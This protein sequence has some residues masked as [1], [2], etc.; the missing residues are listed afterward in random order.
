MRFIKSFIA[1]ISRHAANIAILVILVAVVKTDLERQY[2]KQ[3]DRLL[4]WDVKVYYVY[5]PA[6]FIYH[7][8]S[9]KFVAEKKGELGEIM[10][11]EESPKGMYSI[12]TTYGQALLYAPFFFAAHAYSLLTGTWE[13]TGYSP[14]YKFG[15]MLSSVF[16]L[17]IGLFFLKKFLLKYF[18]P[19]VTGLTLIAIVLATNIYYYSTYEAAMTHAY[20]FSMI[21]VF[22]YFT[23]KW[24]EKTSVWNTIIIGF[25]IGLITLVRP[26]NLI[27]LLFFILWGVHSGQSLKERIFY[28]LKAYKWILLMLLIF[29][30]LWVPQFIYWKYISG[31]YLFYSYSDQRF[32]FDAPQ[33]FSSLFSY[34]KGLLVYIPILVFAFIGI[35]FLYKKYQGFILPVTVVIVVNIYVLSSWCFWWFG[36]GFGPRSYIDTYAFLAIPFAALTSWINRKHFIW[37]ILFLAITGSLLW[38]NLFQTRQYSRGTINW[39]AMNKEAY[40]EVFLKKHPSQEFYDMLR[41]PNRDS[42]VKG[43]YYKGDYT[44]DEVHHKEKASLNLNDTITD[45]RERYIINFGKTVRMY[46]VWY[47][48]MKDKAAENGISLD[49][50]I[51]KDAIWLWGQEQQKKQA[52]KADSLSGIS[53]KP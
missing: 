40:W 22:I 2:W 23:T 44:W 6:A 1:F 46:D 41:F 29:F 9:L 50:M 3:R 10:Y 45:E 7:D 5:L 51:R 52:A 24:Y 37:M 20:N 48:Q 49:S 16:Y 8:F 39:T 47:Q 28:L 17:A 12:Q 25:L 21:A 4:I 19:W 31:S 36:G 27:V 35:P 53:P 26:V 32:F 43:I 30:L 18:T 13:A 14:P 33:I 42:A 34:R 38:F 11:L 15:L